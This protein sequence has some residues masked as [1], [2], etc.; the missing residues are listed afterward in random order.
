MNMGMFQSKHMAR[1][2]YQKAAFGMKAA[3]CVRND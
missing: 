1:K 3:D 2:W